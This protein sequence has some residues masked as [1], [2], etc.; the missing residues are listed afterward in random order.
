V[1]LFVCTRPVRLGKIQGGG[2]FNQ[3]LIRRRELVKTVILAKF[4][5][6]SFTS[7]C[8]AAIENPL[9]TLILHIL[10]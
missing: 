7:P 4:S 2:G 1:T 10:L 6:W 8:H 9:Y 3:P 5:Y